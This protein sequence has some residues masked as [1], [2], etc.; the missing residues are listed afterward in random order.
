[1]NNSIIVYSDCRPTED[2]I[3]DTADYPI[4][5]AVRSLGWVEIG[6]HELTQERSSRAVNK[7]IVDLSVGRRDLNDAVG[8]WGDVSI[9]CDGGM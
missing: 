3:E 2:G 6:E 8:R 1:M 4:R 7:A 9:N 5:Y